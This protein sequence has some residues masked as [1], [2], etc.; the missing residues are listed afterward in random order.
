VNGTT[1]NAFCRSNQLIQQNDCTS[2]KCPDPVCVPQENYLQ[3]NAAVTT[4]GI[5]GF[6]KSLLA[7]SFICEDP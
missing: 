3:Y 7:T 4:V 6:D 1:Q 2:P 5:D